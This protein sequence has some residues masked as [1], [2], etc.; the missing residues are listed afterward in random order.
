MG[1]FATMENARIL[2]N[3]LELSS[4]QDNPL[5]NPVPD[6]KRSTYSDLFFYGQKHCPSLIRFLVNIV[7]A[8]KGPVEKKDVVTVTFYFAVMAHLASRVNFTV[9]RTKTLAFRKLGLTEP[10]L[11]QLSQLGITETDRNLRKFRDLLADLGETH[12]QAQMRAGLPFTTTTD[13][14]DKKGHHLTQAF[15]KVERKDTR[16]F[17]TSKPPKSETKNWFTLA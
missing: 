1:Y 9:A 2:S 17:S 3:V 5:K 15:V 4:R 8:N 14:L 7:M 13:N 11:E 10:G 6:R 12:F 16:M